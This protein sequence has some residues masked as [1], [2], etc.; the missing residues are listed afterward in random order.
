MNTSVM[1]RRPLRRSDVWVRQVNQENAIY[2]PQGGTVHLLNETA[3]AIWQLCDGETSVEE[4]VGAI[5][6][7]TGM[8][9]DVVIEDVDRVLTEF[10]SA[11]LVTWMV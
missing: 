6:D 11:G 4:M 3:L 7:L 9:R 10:G 2:D 1:N 5:C 8:H